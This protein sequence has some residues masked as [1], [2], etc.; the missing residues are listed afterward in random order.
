MDCA[1][2]T[3]DRRPDRFDLVESERVH[4]D[5]KPGF[6]TTIGIEVPPAMVFGFLADPSTASVIDPA[7]MRYDPEGG[8]MG[9]GPLHPADASEVGRTHLSHR[10]ATSAGLH[11]GSRLL[12]DAQIGR[13]A[14]AGWRTSLV[15]R[16]VR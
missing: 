3:T 16:R 10:P 14:S 9:L 8:T 7:V 15:R 11:P 5:M 1:A 12:V 6:S 4:V 2:G 13:L